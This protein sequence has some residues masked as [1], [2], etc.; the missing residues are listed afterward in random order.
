V[1]EL[2]DD[3]LGVP[4]PD[5]DRGKAAGVVFAHDL[6]GRHARPVKDRVGIAGG[7]DPGDGD[8]V[9]DI[10]A[11]IL[12]DAIGEPREEQHGRHQ[13]HPGEHGQL[14][15]VDHQGW[16]AAEPPG[17]RPQGDPGQHGQA[18]GGRQPIPT[19]VGERET[20]PGE[21]GEREDGA[22]DHCLAGGQGTARRRPE[23]SR[24]TAGRVSV[25]EG[26]I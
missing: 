9:G 23:R 5:P 14:S 10:G 26:G 15:P 6:D 4:V 1:I 19:G 25:C 21:H 24:P 2:Q 20:G 3:A 12:A 17:D 11:G 22:K 13:R 7:P 8:R 18:G 16:P